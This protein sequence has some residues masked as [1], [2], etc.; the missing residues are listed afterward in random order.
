MASG[1]IIIPN[2]T[3]TPAILDRITSEVRDRLSQTTKDPA[4]Y[5][6]VTSLT[7]VSSLPVFQV[8]GGIYRLVRIAVSILRGVDGR[9][10]S[11]QVT[12]EHI[13]WRYS[14]DNWRNFIELSRLKGDA[15]ET[16]V[17]RTGETGIEWKYMSEEDTLYKVLVAYDVLKLKFTDLSEEQKEELKL[18]FSDLS[19]EDIAAL[20]QPAKDATAAAVEAAS[21]AN[22]AAERA[23]EAAE[24]AETATEAANTAEQQRASA[25]TER[26][27]QEALRLDA[28]EL[29]N[30]AEQERVMAEIERK[31]AETARDTAEQERQ[32]SETARK[33]SETVR[34]QQET[35]R[36]EAEKKRTEAEELRVAAETLRDRSEQTRVSQEAARETAEELRDAAEQDRAEAET[37]RAES[38]TTRK[39][40]EEARTASENLRDTA[41][42][43][44]AA[45]EEERQS[46]EKERNTNETVRQSQETK[47]QTDMQA[48]IEQAGQAT[49]EAN[50]AADRANAAAAKAENIVSGILPDW[51]AGKDS[52][53]YI[54]NKPEIPTLDAAPTAGT[55]NYDNTDG[56][57]VSFCIGDEVRVLEEDEYVFYRLYDLR[58]GVAVWQESGSGTALPGNVYLTGA[59][60]YNKSV[61]TIRQGYLKDE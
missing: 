50:K 13:Q 32:Q 1:D 8:S 34:R 19:G 25:E 36:V 61:R 44:R 18:H 3:I 45:S 27:Q 30:E 22:G 49:G 29:R 7:G 4:D 9:E 31:A 21:A 46:A 11:L 17:F 24:K 26:A 16:P 60:Y 15:G 6:E 14:N 23:T 58:D 55:L 57:E 38:E 52:P 43:S 28:E 40:D 51:L 47:R 42:Q 33:E 20:Q 10:V 48:A 41:E 37:E 2:N 56:T 12:D 35:T 59:N 53:N 5:E 39:A 54:R